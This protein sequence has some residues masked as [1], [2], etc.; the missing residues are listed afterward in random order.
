MGPNETAITLIGGPRIIVI[1]DV[2]EYHRVQIKHFFGMQ[3]GSQTPSGLD[4]LLVSRLHRM[5]MRLG[6]SIALKETWS[7]GQT[8]PKVAKARW[9]GEHFESYGLPRAAASAV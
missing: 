1:F 9:A 8:L 6:L 5:R 7:C 2:H 3:T 4:L